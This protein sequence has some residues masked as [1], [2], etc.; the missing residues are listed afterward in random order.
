M[1]RNSVSAKVGLA[2]LSSGLIKESM[3]SSKKFKPV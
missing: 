2:S 3:K 1:S